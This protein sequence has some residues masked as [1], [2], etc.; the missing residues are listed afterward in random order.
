[1][2]KQ[3]NIRKQTYEYPKRKPD[4]R[5]CGPQQFIVTRQKVPEAFTE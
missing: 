4:G 3:V 1:M 2:Q 5:N